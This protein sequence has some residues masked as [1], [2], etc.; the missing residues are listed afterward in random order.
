MLNTK[1]PPKRRVTS[2]L[3]R[4]DISTLHTIGEPSKR[5]AAA[6]PVNIEI[7]TA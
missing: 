7:P 6:A 5:E 1:V 2:K 3:T 4:M